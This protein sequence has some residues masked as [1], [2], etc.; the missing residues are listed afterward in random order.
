MAIKKAIDAGCKRLLI[1]C[2]DTVMVST[3]NYTYT[4]SWT[5]CISMTVQDLW[6][7]W[8]MQMYAY[9][10]IHAPSDTPAHPPTPSRPTLYSHA[11]LISH[12]F[13]QSSSLRTLRT[14]FKGRK[15]MELDTGR[16]WISDE[17]INKMDVY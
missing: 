10:Y 8:E 1:R 13:I 9:H 11:L 3:L 7:C 2:M 12:R 5:A 17:R 6:R 15:S 16:V 4:L 14:T